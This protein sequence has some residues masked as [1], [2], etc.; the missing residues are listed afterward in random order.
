MKKYFSFRSI[1]AQL[2][3]LLIVA[4]WVLPTF[5]LLGL[6]LQGQSA[7]GVQW[8]VDGPV[9]PNPLRHAAH[10]RHTKCGA[11][12]RRICD[13]RAAISTRVQTVRLAEIFFE[14][15]MPGTHA[16]GATVVLEDG[17]IF[18]EEDGKPDGTI[19]VAADSSY[20]M[21]LTAP[22]DKDVWGS[23]VLC[24]GVAAGVRD[25]ELRASDCF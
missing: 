11:S 2:L 9:H 12:G 8:L 6:Q 5:G 4:V 17:Q 23:G 14:V 7:A 22:Y 21:A 20:R 16:M 3:L 18:D 25:R 24:G 13:H 15:V 1:A 10:R 19:T